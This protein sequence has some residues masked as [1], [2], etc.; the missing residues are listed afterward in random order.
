MCRG[1]IQWWQSRTVSAAPV[2]G[3]TSS[4]GEG[5]TTSAGPFSQWSLCDCP[6]LDPGRWWCPGTWMTPLQS[7]CCSW[8]WVRVSGGRAGGLLLKSTIISTVLS[9]LSS[10]L[11]R[12]H[13]QLLNLLSVSRLVT[14]LDEADQ[15]GVVCKLQEL[16]WSVEDLCGDGGQHRF[17]GRLVS[18]RWAWC[19]PSLVH[20]EDLAHVVFTYLQYKCRCGG[21][22]GCRRCEWCFFKPAIELIQMVCQLLILHSAGGWCLVT[23]DDFHT[24]PHWSSITGREFV[25]LFISLPE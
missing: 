18:H 12:L 24:F 8:W 20:S 17:S 13:S 16:Q 3:W 11:L 2:A 9:V 15:C 5:C 25:P 23:G 21:E 1:R 4:A 6:T 22:G 14:A 10:R 7:Q 19:L